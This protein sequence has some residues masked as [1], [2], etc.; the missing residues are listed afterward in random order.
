MV[1]I[2][3]IAL[4]DLAPNDGQ[5]EGLPKNPRFIKD[6][7]FKD[8]VKS[9]GES[10]EMLKLR[11]LIVVPH[12]GRFIII[13]GNM[14]YRAA[15]ELG[16][17]ELP[18]KILPQDTPVEKLR[19]Y[20]IKDNSNYGAWDMDMLGNEWDTEL[21]SGWGLDIDW[22]SDEGKKEVIEDDFDVNADNVKTDIV[23]G[24][25]FEIG[26]HRL[27]CGDSTDSDQVAKLMNGAK[28]DLI[29]TDPPYDLEDNYSHNIFNSAKEDCHIFI[30][31]SD[32]LLIDNVINGLQW[33]RKFFAV[34]FRQAR[35]VSNNQP[36]TRVDIIA[37]FNKGKTKFNNLKDGFSTLIECAKIHNDNEKINFGHKQAKKI[38]LPSNF[39]QHYSKDGELVTD[40]FGGSGSTMAAC[41]QLNRRCYMMEYD[42]KSC[43]I[44]IDRMKKV[45]QLESIKIN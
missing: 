5:I 23:P 8:L 45:Y 27:L 28:A 26:S 38:E 32:R 36:M 37:E 11:E 33:F 44:I 42:P 31:N 17:E 20:T 6:D 3:D 21:L 16:M 29:F 34:D 18:C 22:E 35:L 25:L 30:M 2:K 41:E 19:E 13:A 1:E 10:P 14:R 9:L 39:I 40:L 43:Q 15:M 4:K 7:K 24:D 12:E